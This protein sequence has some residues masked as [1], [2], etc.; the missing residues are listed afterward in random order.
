MATTT[1][2]AE[3]DKAYSEQETRQRLPITIDIMGRLQA[4]KFSP[5]IQWS[6]YDKT[7]VWAACC[8]GFFGFMRSGEFTSIRQGSAVTITNV[9]V[10]S[11]TNPSVVKS[12]DRPIWQG[13]GHI[14][15]QNG[16]VRMPC[17]STFAGNPSS[18]SWST[19]H[20]VRWVSALATTVRQSGQGA[21]RCVRHQG[22]GHSFRIGADT[23]AAQ[24]GLPAYLIK[25][26]GR[27]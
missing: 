2:R 14:L 3:G 11:P 1:I 25:T 9:A 5:Q 10:D 17:D 27:W 7:M 16:S 8:M 20:L 18:R 26:I 21:F 6:D 24:A 15:G 13:R 23:T 22:Q 4:T 19:I 12:K